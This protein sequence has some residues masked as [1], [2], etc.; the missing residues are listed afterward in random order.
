MVITNMLD[1][2]KACLVN[3][4]PF[5]SPTGRSRLRQVCSMHNC[6]CHVMCFKLSGTLHGS[7]GYFRRKIHGV[8]KG[9]AVLEP[10]DGILTNNGKE[11]QVA[12]DNKRTFVA[13]H[14]CT[15][16]REE[17]MGSGHEIL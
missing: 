9:P 17:G 5:P 4:C 15:L 2:R 7:S 11:L 10:T 1:V 8:N 16:L 3:S 12:V 14:M 13:M 6:E